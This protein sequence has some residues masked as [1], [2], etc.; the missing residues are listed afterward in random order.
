MNVLVQ[1][2]MDKFTT[3]IMYHKPTFSGLYTWWDSYCTTG[4]E[5]SPDWIVDVTCEEDLF[6]TVSGC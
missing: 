3:T 1:R 6:A 5:D 2:K 4:P